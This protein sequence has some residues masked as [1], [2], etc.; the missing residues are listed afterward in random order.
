[1]PPPCPACPDHARTRG[2]VAR[3]SVPTVPLKGHTVEARSSE[4]ART[5]VPPGEGTLPE[6]RVRVAEL[7]H[8]V[9]RDFRPCAGESVAWRIP[10]TMRSRDYDRAVRRIVRACEAAGDRWH[11]GTLIQPDRGG[12]PGLAPGLNVVAVEATAWGLLLTEM[13]P[14]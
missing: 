14:C 6:V 9:A 4:P 8:R 2:T 13:R 7:S 12:V 5:T 1:M 3:A 10:D 11:V